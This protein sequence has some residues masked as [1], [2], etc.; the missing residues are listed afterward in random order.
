[1]EQ[2]KKSRALSKVRVAERLAGKLVNA[3]A[4]AHAQV[5][6]ASLTMWHQSQDLRSASQL[7]HSMAISLKHQVEK[8]VRDGD[9]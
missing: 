7:A 1:V 4:E 6:S 5:T 8:E 9:E 2:N 3:C